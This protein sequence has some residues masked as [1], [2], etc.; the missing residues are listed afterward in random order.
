MLILKNFVF[1]FSLPFTNFK[2]LPFLVIAGCY[3]LLSGF[4]TVD[5]G[6]RIHKQFY[7]EDRWNIRYTRN[8]FPKSRFKPLK[9]LI[10][11]KPFKMYQPE[12][13]MSIID[14]PCC[15]ITQLRRHHNPNN[16][17]SIVSPQVP[18]MSPG[19]CLMFDCEL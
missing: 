6:S 14:T 4:T 1:T 10:D 3:I 9:T 7:K 15:M 19:L 12:P 13:I 11:T 17:S 5:Q 18:V 16:S 8:S 2:L